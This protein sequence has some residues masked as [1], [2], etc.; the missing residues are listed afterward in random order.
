MRA[1]PDIAAAVRRSY[2]RDL[3]GVGA[4]L[5]P[6]VPVTDLPAP[7]APYLEA[8]AEL[9][10][11][12]PRGCGGV[13][14]WLDGEFRRD[15]PMVRRAIARLDEGESDAL[16][17]ALC[18]LAHTYRWGSVPPEPERFDEGWIPLPAGIAGPW[19]A[20]ARKLDR[21]RVGSA[22]NFHLTNWQMAGRPGGSRYRPEE[23][24]RS[25]VRIARTWLGPPIDAQLEAF[26]VAFVLMEAQ[27]ALVLRAIVEAIE[28]AAGGGVDEAVAALGRLQE[29]IAAMTLGFSMNVRRRTVDPSVWLELIQ[30]TFA[31]AAYGDDPARLEGGPSGMQLGTVHAL[32]AAMGVRGRSVLA[33]LGASARLHMPRRHREFLTTLDCGGPLLRT[34]VAGA[35]CPE[36]SSR[37]DGCVAALGS[38]RVT[39]RARGAQYLRHRP[40]GEVP[41]ASTGLTIGV[42]DDAG[43]TFDRTMSARIEETQ[44]A[45]LRPGRQ[46]GFAMPHRS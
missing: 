14:A 33:Q 18:A 44:A 37:F 40:A 28:A 39:H 11:R 1:F 27:G 41:R 20:V 46:R 30:P 15:D 13:R 43:C 24:T 3:G 9:P 26:S 19:G 25:T 35:G 5:P 21:P 8:C 45:A 4:F 29:A 16:M 17:T 6:L 31:W 10:S 42:D 23:L 36:L 7:L 32:D 22:W 38:F 2:E 34:F 12:Y